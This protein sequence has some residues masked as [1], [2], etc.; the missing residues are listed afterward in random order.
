MSEVSETKKEVLENKKE[1]S[2]TKMEL[3]ALKAASSEDSPSALTFSSV[4][5]AEYEALANNNIHIFLSE[6]CGL[7]LMSE[8]PTGVA[9][10]EEGK[11][12]SQ[13]DGLFSLLLLAP[14][15]PRSLLEME[16][17]KHVLYGQHAAGAKAGYSRPEVLV[18]ARPRQLTPT[19]ERG[20][21][22]TRCDYLGVF[23]YTMLDN[24]SV[25][26]EVV[27][28]SPLRAPTSP[29]S[30]AKSIVRNSLLPRLNNRLDNALLRA[31]IAAAE[32]GAPLPTRVSDIVAV[33][34][35]VGQCACKESVND[36]LAS[37]TGKRRWPHLHEMM[38]RRRFVFFHMIAAKKTSVL[39]VLA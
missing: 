3:A 32:D 29:P 37:P 22:S 20:G 9:A 8:L 25:D 2:E 30:K 15:A 13:W 21:V 18:D 39:S 5:G 4:R 17:R 27:Q 38:E 33:V 10:T 26:T 36:L 24:W 14:W 28:K 19:K 7:N 12:N 16:S 11:L 34:G 31:K 1:A 23:E 35:V 6:W